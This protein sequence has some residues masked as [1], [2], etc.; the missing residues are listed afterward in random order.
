[1]FFF[2]N[3]T[4]DGGQQW[5]GGLGGWKLAAEIRG[6]VHAPGM[7]RLPSSPMLA[8]SFAVP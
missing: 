3:E 8:L 2:Y 5:S 1:M 7:P 6:P 4:R